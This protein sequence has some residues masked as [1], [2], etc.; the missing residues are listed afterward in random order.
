MIVG[1]RFEWLSELQPKFRTL[2]NVRRRHLTG[3][4]SERIAGCLSPRCPDRPGFAV[5]L[6]W[7]YIERPIDVDTTDHLMTKRTQRR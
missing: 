3:S 1:D 4:S 2:S 6:H 5:V 7:F